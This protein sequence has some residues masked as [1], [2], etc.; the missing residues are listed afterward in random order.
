VEQALTRLE[1][2]PEMARYLDLPAMRARWQKFG[3][4]DWQTAPLNDVIGVVQ[5]LMGAIE[6]SHFIR[7]FKGRN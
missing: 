3:E 5:G 6:T 2:D 4:T 7:W 1:A